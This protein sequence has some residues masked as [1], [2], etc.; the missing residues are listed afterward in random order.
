MDPDPGGQKTRGSVSG[1]GTLPK[2]RDCL[3]TKRADKI[4]MQCCGKRTAGTATF[5]LSGTGTVMHS[6]SGSGSDPDPVLEL[7]LDLDTI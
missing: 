3:I 7:V 2:T 6:G 4:Y 5:G 1:S